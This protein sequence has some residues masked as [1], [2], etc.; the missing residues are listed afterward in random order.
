MNPSPRTHIY[1]LLF[2][3]AILIGAF[4]GIRALAIPESWD[5]AHW[6]RRDSL[7]DIQHL[8]RHFAGNAFCGGSGCHKKSMRHLEKMAL[9]ET[10]RHQGLACEV[11]HGPMSDH[12]KDGEKIAP[13]KITVANSLCLSCH[14]RLTGR[15]QQFPQ[16]D[17]TSV[18]HKLLNV[19]KIAICRACHDP[20][21][22]N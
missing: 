12:A 17:E 11:C 8:P 18:A 3:L 6:F 14:A 5:S 19:K 20:H 22:P 10:G 1:R 9:L 15:P 13:A 21:K 2:A 7:I 16:F 4:I